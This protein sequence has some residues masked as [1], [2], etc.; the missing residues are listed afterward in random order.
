MKQMKNR[1]LN[2]LPAI[3]LLLIPTINFAQ[4]PTLGS[5]AGFVLFTSVGA[6]SN[7]GAGYLTHLT[8]NVG[9]NSGSSTGFGNVDGVMH[10]GD[11]ATGACAA[12][13][14]TLYGQ[15]NTATATFF[16]A[17]LLGN[18]DTLVPGVYHISADATLNLD[19]VL[20]GEGNPNALFIFQI[21]GTLSTNAASKIVLI[22]STLACNVFWKVEGLVSMASASTMRGTIVANNAAINMS[23]NDTLEGRA[24]STTGAVSVSGILAYTP[25]GCGSAILTGPAAPALASTA[26]YGV[27]SGNGMVANTGI[28]YVNGDV[29]TNVGLTTGFNPLL[30]SGMIH[31]IPDASTAAAASDLTNVYNYLET[32]PYD[33]QLLYPAQFG[34]NLVLTPHT[35]LM[36]AAV[37]L[38]GNVYL[39]AEGDSN[40]VFVIQVNGAFNTSTF[41]DVVL[42]NGALAKNVYWK[43]DG[44]VDISGNSNIKGNIV[45]N[46]AGITLNTG[47]T[48]IGRAMTT[49]GAININGSDINRTPTSCTAPAISGI[50]HVCAGS[51]DMLS[52]STAGGTWSS[53][54]TTVATIGS[55]SGIVSG[56]NAGNDVI[57]YVTSAGCTSTTTFTVTGGP[58]MINGPGT[59]CSGS[60]ITLTDSASGGTWSSSNSSLATVGSGTG[61]VTGVSAGTPVI[62]YMLSAGCMAVKTISVSPSSNAGVITGSSS[63]CVG[64]DILLAD[65]VLGGA[66]SSSNANATVSPTGLVMGISAGLATINYAVSNSCG[67]SYATKNIIITTIASAGTISGPSSVCTGS[68]ITLSSTVTGG[69]WASHNP[70]TA[71]ITPATGVATGVSAGTVIISYTVITSCG[72][73]TTTTDISVN[74]PPAVS[75]I[76]GPSSVC[77]SSSITLT[78]S[79]AGGVW[80]SANT[81]ATITDSGVVSGDSAGTD[82]IFYTVSSTCGTAMASKTITV[83]PLPDAGRIRGSASVCLG[84]SIDLTDALT[85]GTWSISNSDATVSDSGVVMGISAGVSIVTYAV[86]NSCETAFV[87]KSITITTVATAGAISGPAVVCIGADTTFSST[88]LGGTWES[89]DPSSAAVNSS[90][91]VVTGIASGTAIISYTVMSACGTATTVTPVAVNAAPAAGSIAGAAGVCVGSSVILT[92]GSAGGTWSSGNATASVSGGMVTGNAAGTDIIS[93]IVA[94]SCGSASA[95]KSITVNPLPTA[96]TLTGSEGMCVGTAIT[97]TETGGTPGGVWS[98]SSANATVTPLGVVTGVSPGTATISYVVTNPCGTA[99]ATKNIIVTT[100][101]IAGTISGPSSV[102]IGADITLTGSVIGGTWT[103]SNPPAAPVTLGTGAVSGVSLGTTI[104]TY[105]ITSLCG[106]A[107]VTTTVTV[108]PAPVAGSISGGT[109]V[110]AG[111]SITL[112]DAISGG[113]WSSSNSAAS[114]TGGTVTGLTAGMA[115][116]QYAVTNS[117]GTDTA[118]KI[119][120]VNPLP[121]A[122]VIT[123]GTSVCVAGFLSLDDDA[124]GGVWTSSNA[125]A[126]VIDGLVIGVFPGVDTISYS[127][128]TACGTAVP[129]VQYVTVAP[130]PDAGTITGATSVCVGASVILTDLATGGVWSGSNGTAVVSGGMVTGVTAGIDSVIY[131]VANACEIL[132]TIKT[133]TINP[134]PVADAITGS[135]TVCTGSAITLADIAAGGVWSS[136]NANATVTGGVVT[137]HIAGTDII[138]YAVTN[139]CGID[140]ATTTITVD[141]LPAVAAIT[142]AS[143]VCA[144]ASVSLADLTAGGI[145]S[146]SNADATVAGG[147]VTGVSA[148]TDVISYAVTNLC[149]TATVSATITVNALPDAGTIAGTS[150]VCPG[151]TITL[152]DLVT[153]GTWSAGNTNAT[154]SLTGLVSGITAGMDII[155]YGVTN[156][157]GSASAT[158]TITVNP[159]PDAGVI[160]GVSVI[161]TGSS[162]TLSDS[163]AGGSWS[164]GNA[165]AE[166]LDGLILGAI[167]GTDT[168]MYTVANECG[169]DIASKVITVNPLPYAGHITGPPDVC[170]GSAITLSDLTTGGMWSSSNS[171]I[172]TVS[173]GMVTSVAAGMDTI[174]Y[175]FI[176]SCGTAVAMQT[177]V[178]NTA[179]VVPVITTQGPGSACTGTLYQNFGTATPPPA[180]TS[181]TWTADNATVWAEGAL[182][183]YSLISFT[184]AGTAT[185]YLNVTGINTTCSVKSSVTVTVGADIAPTP[186]VAYFNNHFVCTPSDLGSYQWGYDDVNTLDSSLFAGEINQDYINTNPDFANKYYWVMTT[187]GSCLQKTYYTTPLGVQNVNKDVAE[188]TAYPNPA[189]SVIN[190]AVSMDVQGKVLIDVLNIMGQKMTEAQAIDNKAAID[191]TALP[192]GTYFITCYRDGVNIGHSK[193]I[194]N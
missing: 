141:A 179:P 116:I 103:S 46:N 180:N 92:D 138:R 69:V 154:V 115:T 148:G 190:V 186:L 124:T 131:T 11:A 188:I 66:W 34:N 50:K 5:T 172:A 16:P 87:T 81:T 25:I 142:G 165:S 163:V 171:A 23:T 126:T 162:V 125:S 111:S 9:S 106:T 70:A 187:D 72:I 183:Q 71:S 67:S 42:I 90:S 117:C 35:Y 96:G 108:D 184:E 98:S 164:A 146:S 73:A 181:Y 95:T 140:T 8:G 109:A 119:V 137:G 28:T 47:D 31:P 168:I 13:L 105:T 78:D 14:L 80:S 191:V 85:G 128:T 38:T 76:R 97:L 175:S 61:V 176:N 130:L 123:G 43:I 12:D 91:G 74:P 194:K 110:C 149:G 99:F 120:T 174:K 64:S 59:V 37:M 40:A 100:T 127:V 150:V 121:D 32:L 63:V 157:C 129:A 158:T 53:A 65:T 75:I 177:V 51:T 79:T 1:L 44:A 118:S 94:N 82:T 104:I 173:G 166:A 114:V 54:N 112:T 159:L 113:M 182:H 21:E 77:V 3:I 20:N 139:V 68:S 151:A 193:F 145:W 7:T 2:V 161:C 60:S 48:L 15:L 170:L 153:G 26:S 189:S 185:V 178:V 133:I 93:Y 10:S 45:A 136:S 169:V 143:M 52:D 144:G 155:S 132:T 89:S 29:G 30:V 57:T 27:F 147:I 160:T 135:A 19:L 4:A 39:N 24:L 152:N 102:C 6:V 17:P 56:L 18:G 36:N 22:N 62:T 41:A 88:V 122:G 83:N 156:M 192:A 101:A 49:N 55:S 58:S 107:R 134:L 84:S 33:I 167:A 86:E